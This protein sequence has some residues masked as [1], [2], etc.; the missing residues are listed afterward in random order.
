MAQLS[1][2]DCKFMGLIYSL[3]T[4]PCLMLRIIGV[5]SNGNIIESCRIIM[6]ASLVSTV[7]I[8]IVSSVRVIFETGLSNLIINLNY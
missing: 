4:A 2:S 7:R 8:L 6:L 3:G 5:L 1:I